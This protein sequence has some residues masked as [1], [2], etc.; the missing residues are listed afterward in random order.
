MNLIDSLKEV[1]NKVGNLSG[2]IVRATA[3]S[4]GIE[5]NQLFIGKVISILLVSLIF[6]LILKFAG[7]LKTPVK[8]VILVLLGILAVSIMLSFIS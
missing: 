3:D 5:L 6:Y 1:G 7:A 4:T 2:N 8:L